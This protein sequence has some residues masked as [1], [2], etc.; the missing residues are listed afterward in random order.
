VALG[1]LDDDNE[2]NL[3]MTDCAA[4][5]MPSQMRST[6]VILLVVNKVVHPAGL[7]DNHWRA[8]G[9]DFVHM[10]IS[11]EHP[12]S[13]EHRMVLVLVGINMR[14]EATH[15]HVKGF[16]LPMP[17]EEDTREVE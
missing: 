12:I 14:L 17:N 7:F 1:F 13:D 5:V 4:Y 8:I 10:L 11:E 15:T 9:E 6:F 16:N 2:W 3:V